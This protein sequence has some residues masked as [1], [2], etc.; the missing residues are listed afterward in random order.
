MIFSNSVDLVLF[1]DYD[2]N[3]KYF[4]FIIWIGWYCFDIFKAIFDKLKQAFDYHLFVVVY[5]IHYLSFV[6]FWSD[7]LYSFFFFCWLFWNLILFVIFEIFYFGIELVWFDFSL[8][9][10]YSFRLLS[11]AR[12]IILFRMY[13]Y[14][15]QLVSPYEF[16]YT[17]HIFLHSIHNSLLLAFQRFQSAFF[18]LCSPFP[19]GNCQR[20]CYLC[21]QYLSGLFVK[22][23]F[24]AVCKW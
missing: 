6:A 24:S 11:F 23:W 22:W 16:I 10:I 7:C 20:S 12:L 18:P 21:I 8:I 13:N 4:L 9:R 5:F 2:I 3:F 14:E 1:I 17:H 19:I 15:I